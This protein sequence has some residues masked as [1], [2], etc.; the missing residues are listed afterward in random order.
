[1]SINQNQ[2]QSIATNKTLPLTPINTPLPKYSF[3]NDP[4]IGLYRT[5]LGEIK[6]STNSTNNANPK[7]CY[8]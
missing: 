4:D 6:F 5:G 8:E 7:N 3:N 1:M 2:N